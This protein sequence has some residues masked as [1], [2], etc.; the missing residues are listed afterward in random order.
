MAIIVSDTFNRADSPTSLGTADTGQVWSTFEGEFG[1]LSNTAT[2][3][4]TPTS[5]S[6]VALIDTG[7]TEAI[8]KVTLVNVED[9][10][11][12]AGNMGIIARWFDSSHFYS[13]TYENFFGT[14]HVL[15]LKKAQ[16]GTVTI[17]DQSVVLVNGD[18]IA[19]GYCGT[20]F[21]VYINDVLQYTVNSSYGIPYG[22]VSGLKSFGGTIGLHVPQ[23]QWD[24]FSVETF[25]TCTPTYNCLVESGECVD[26]EDGTGT[27]ATLEACLEGCSVPAS[28]TCADNECF[29]PGDGSGEFTTLLE[30]EQSGCAGLQANT[31]RFD[32]GEG[33]NWYVVASISDSGDELRSKV[34]KAVRVTSRRTNSSAMAFGYDVNQEISISDLETGTRSNSRMTTNP[35]SFTDSAEVSQSERKPINITNAVLSTVRIEGDDTGNEERDTIHEITVE[36]A[37]QGVRR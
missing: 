2:R 1:I 3:F 14:T 25:Q 31:L 28:Y 8:T 35:Q 34:L 19:L 6:G 18:T 26:P 7:F 23:T 30:C 17:G 37:I 20:T 33:S 9:L 32:S 16:G 5:T 29:D 36:Q 22:T 12:A 15:R 10:P 11:G 21:Y 4:N 24:N 13:L 27:Y